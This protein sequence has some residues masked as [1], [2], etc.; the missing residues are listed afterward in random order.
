[1][2]TRTFKNYLAVIVVAVVKKV[3]EL[4]LREKDLQS[5]ISDMK[6]KEK[7]IGIVLVVSWV[8][9]C[10]LVCL[11]CSKGLQ[12]D[13]VVGNVIWQCHRGMLLVVGGLF[14][15]PMQMVFGSL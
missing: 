15:G 1:M 2:Y 3:D 8:C 7:I 14:A 13:N 5:R 10:L 9:V 4:K 11:L 12:F 6:M